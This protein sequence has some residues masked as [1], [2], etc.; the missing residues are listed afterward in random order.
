M[1]KRSNGTLYF[2]LVNNVFS[3]SYINLGYPSQYRLPD[4][5]I[6][7]NTFKVN[8][9]LYT[10]KDIELIK[11]MHP[12]VLVIPYEDIDAHLYKHLAFYRTNIIHQPNLN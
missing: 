6:L 10:K 12:D 5:Y 4:Y 9:I 8:T 3:L 11:E 2:A 7:T 1:R